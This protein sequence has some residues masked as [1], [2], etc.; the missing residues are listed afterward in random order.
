MIL[1]AGYLLHFHIIEKSDKNLKHSSVHYTYKDK[2]FHGIM[3]STHDQWWRLKQIVFFVNGKKQGIQYE[4]FENGQLA[5]T[6]E[7]KNGLQ[8]GNQK[9]WYASGKEESISIFKNGI[10]EGESWA[11]HPN[12]KIRHF[13]LYENGQE[14][15]FKSWTGVGKPFYNYVYHGGKKVGFEGGSFCKP[16]RKTVFN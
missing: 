12:G 15:A 4:W 10:I 1:F 9:S 6:I 8:H 7:Y 16:K 3:Y 14:I 13:V 2:T 11:W 5:R